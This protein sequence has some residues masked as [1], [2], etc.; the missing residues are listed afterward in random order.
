M[1]SLWD[2]VQGYSHFQTNTHPVP[3]SA[4]AS[5]LFLPGDPKQLLATLI[6]SLN[7]CFPPSQSLTILQTARRLISG[8]PHRHDSPA[9][10][11]ATLIQ[12]AAA[13]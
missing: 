9:M 6:I 4:T 10:K 5:V 3:P 7:K 11:Q 8:L 2:F 1:S 13:I 12:T